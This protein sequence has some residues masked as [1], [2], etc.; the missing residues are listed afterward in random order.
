MIEQMKPYL[1]RL[2]DVVD[3]NQFHPEENVL[4][5]SVQ[6]FRI[7]RKEA[8]DEYELQIAGLLHDVGKCKRSH[9]H[10]AIS[11]D[12]CLTNDINQ[13]QIIHL[14]EEHMRIQSFIAGSM[15]KLGKV[16]TL[17]NSVYFRNL[18][19]LHRA[20]KLARK[21]D[22]P[23]HA[24]D[25]R[26]ELDAIWNDVVFKFEVVRQRQ[27]SFV[28]QGKLHTTEQIRENGRLLAQVHKETD[29]IRR[30]KEAQIAESNAR[31][32]D[33]LKAASELRIL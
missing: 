25:W 13:P 30:N 1:Q 7:L 6:T 8:P 27:R 22:S 11:V 14:I 15:R 23:S 20:D 2:V 18:V 26:D 21:P 17:L 24:T 29:Q 12:L 32:E 31:V 33:S 16:Q 19:H 5:H 9:G 4:A 28:Y 10:E 3:N